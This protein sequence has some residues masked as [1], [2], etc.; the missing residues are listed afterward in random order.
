MY[1][2]FFKNW[3]NILR[4]CNYEN[5]YKMAW[6]KAITE[7]AME[8]NFDEKKGIYDETITIEQIAHK[9]I[10]YYWNQTIYFNLIQGSNPI[11]PPAIITLVKELIDCYYENYNI[12][13]P[14]TGGRETSEKRPPLKNMNLSAV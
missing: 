6:A 7:I 10:K 3:I 13:Q 11:K 2:N 14:N 9:V 8:T 5:T 1:T 4:N 12:K